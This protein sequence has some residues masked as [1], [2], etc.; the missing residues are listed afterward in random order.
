MTRAIWWLLLP[1]VLAGFIIEVMDGDF[2]RS[3]GFALAIACVF[4]IRDEFVRGGSSG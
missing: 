4:G 3:L 1:C 2:W